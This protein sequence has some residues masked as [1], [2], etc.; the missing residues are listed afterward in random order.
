MKT[1]EIKVSRVKETEG[2]YSATSPQDAVRYWKENIETKDWFDSEREQLIVLVVN[3]RFRILGHS[4]VSIG[5]INESLCHPRDVFRP[6]IALGGYGCLLMHNH[7]T[8]IT[9]PS[10]ADRTSTARMREGA[11]ILGVQLLDHIIVGTAEPDS[12]PFYSFKEHY[13]L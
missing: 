9:D 8:G 13:L 5:T 7:P 11:K 2:T 6:V 4:I 10:E 3:T 1:F 12:R